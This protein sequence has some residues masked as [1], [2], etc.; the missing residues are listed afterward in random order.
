MDLFLKD[1]I[2]IVGG[3][4]QGIGYGIARTLGG[5]GARPAVADADLE[6]VRAQVLPPAEAPFAVATAEHGVPGDPLAEPGRVG[7]RPE[8]GHG[9]A[10]LMTDPDRIR[11]L[12]G[13]QV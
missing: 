3:A 8:R 7:A 6:P 2:A 13:V 11:G 10:P 1:R 12:A 9:A 4:S 5:E